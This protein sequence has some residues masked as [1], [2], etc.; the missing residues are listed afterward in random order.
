MTGRK[1]VYAAMAVALLS[2]L[3]ALPARAQNESQAAILGLLYLP[4]AREMSMGGA[5]TAGATGSAASYYNPALL[6]WQTTPDGK[7]HPR[8]IGSSYYKILQGFGL[9]DMYYMYFPVMF[10]VPDWG[11]FAVNM[12]YLSLGEQQRTD[13]YGVVTGTFK[14][15]TLAV[16]LSYSSRI[17]DNASAG[18]TVKWFYDHLADAG[19]VGEKGE[20][21]GEGFALDA[22][23]LY[24]WR[25]NVTFGAAL[26]NYGPNVQYIDAQQASPTP[27]NFNLGTS[28]KAFDTK[29]NDFTLA[30]DVYKPLVM[31]SKSWYL[32]P[33][34]GWWDEEVYSI[35]EVDGGDDIIHKDK[36]KEERRQ[37]DVR[38]GAEYTYSDYVS[39]RSGYFK[40]WDGAREWLTFG[41]GFRLPIV[42][43]SV[44]VDFGYVYSLKG[45]DDP[46]HGLQIF[47]LGVI[48]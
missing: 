27:V 20:P 21:I 11:E 22:G 23:I 14:T 16:G 3:V 36:F 40:D 38:L 19:A 28:W 18:L 46:N 4:G 6:S 43:A 10:H 1:I 39:L 12:T 24:K 32:A 26:R 17:S 42:A 8:A 30:M 13:E 33:I 35:E 25:E 47:S 41:A 15:Y 37:I 44:K 5:G 34:R 2:G 7:I 48:F 9:N 31:A 29:Y 45:D